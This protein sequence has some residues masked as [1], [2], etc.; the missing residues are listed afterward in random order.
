MRARQAGLTVE[1]VQ[2]DMRDFVRE[3]AFDLALNMY[4]LFGCF[5]DG[6]EDEIM[7]RNVLASLRPGGACIID[8]MGK[9]RL[10]RIFAATTSM[11]LPN[12]GLLVQRHEIVDDWTRIR[13][14]WVIVRKG[15][16]KNYAFD[17]RVY[18]GQELW[19][20]MEGADSWTCGCAAARRRAT[21]GRTPSA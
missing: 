21:T 12:G 9:E 4:T 14:Q 2:A 15:R 20:L 10:A 11:E 18:S 6:R 1:W 3:G 5:Q 8:V 19:M 7:L 16:A 17:H 13:N